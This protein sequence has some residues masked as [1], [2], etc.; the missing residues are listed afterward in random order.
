MWALA[1]IEAGHL[2]A[3]AA[4]GGAILVV[5]LRLGRGIGFY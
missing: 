1:V 2:L 4:L 5:D 3:L